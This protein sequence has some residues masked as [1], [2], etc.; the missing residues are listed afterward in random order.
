MFVVKRLGKNG[1]WSAVSLIDQNGSFRGEAKFETREEAL[2]YMAEYLRRM[3]SRQRASP[4]GYGDVKVFDDSKRDEVEKKKP[5][6]KG[7]KKTR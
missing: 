7:K 2:E 6:G 4:E 3:K 1:M 5:L